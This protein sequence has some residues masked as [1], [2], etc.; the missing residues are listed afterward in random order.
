MANTYTQLYT[1]L[2]FAVKHRKALI[3]PS[4]REEVE[5]YMT[6]ILQNKKHKLLAIYL[7]PDHAHILIGQNPSIALS[8]TV[9]ILKTETSNFIKEKRFLPF[10]FA[11]QEGYGAFSHSRKDLDRVVQYILNQP[12]HHKKRPF[13]QEYLSLL[14]RYEIDFEDQY[15]FDFFDS[16]FE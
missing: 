9:G 10:R 13:K 7:M 16:A 8:K 14:R 12:E 3:K 11:W 6:G 4:F 1:H 15:L 5:R 2:V